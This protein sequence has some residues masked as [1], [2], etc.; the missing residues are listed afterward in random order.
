MLIH[1]HTPK[2]L[3]FG[4]NTFYFASWKSLGYLKSRKLDAVLETCAQ[5]KANEALANEANEA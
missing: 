5:G 2:L 1:F 3:C 4:G